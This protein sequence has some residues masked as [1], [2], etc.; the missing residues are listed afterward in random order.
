MPYL[1]VIE[2]HQNQGSSSA[3]NP[4][5]VTYVF[6]LAQNLGPI[7][8]KRAHFII[9]SSKVAIHLNTQNERLSTS[10]QKVVI[11]DHFWV[12][13]VV[14][15]TVPLLTTLRAKFGPKAATTNF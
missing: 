12:V 5:N 3:K 13:R 14:T 4:F 8:Q 6:V 9:S 2:K 15:V 1:G 11:I 7:S 10:C